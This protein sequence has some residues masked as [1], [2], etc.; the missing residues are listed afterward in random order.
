[1]CATNSQITLSEYK[2]TIISRCRNCKMYNI[3]FRNVH[4]VF[5]ENEYFKF[6]ETL[7]NLYEEDYNKHYPTGQSVLLKNSKSNVGIALDKIEVEQIL[8]AYNEAEIFEEVFAI[9]Y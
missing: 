4:L 1:M 8:R 2:N 3:I 7:C 9:L 5:D 6:K